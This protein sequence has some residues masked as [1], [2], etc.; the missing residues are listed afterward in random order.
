MHTN[1]VLWVR[2][3]AIGDA[4]LSASMLPYVYDRYDHASITV[5]CTDNTAEIYEACPYVDEVIGVEKMRLFIDSGYRNEIVLRLREKGFD[6]AFDTTC[7]LADLGDLFLV[8]S[9]ARERYAFENREAFSEQRLA[10]RRKVYTRLIAFQR[11]H[12]PELERYRDFLYELGVDVPKLEPTVWT[13]KEDDEYAE[14]VFA[15]NRLDPERTLA[16][17]TFGRSHLRT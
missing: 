10:K 5:V 3:D 6:A 17:F 4:I 9:Q 8:G 15:L 16:L 2:L 11:D 14:Q 13:T 12:E 7:A 1:K